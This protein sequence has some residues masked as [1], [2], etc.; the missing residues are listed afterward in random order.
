MLAQEHPSA[1][2]SDYVL[3]LLPAPKLKQIERHLAEC[4]ACLQQV[5]RERAMARAL[6]N[7][8]RDTPLPA[9]GR[10]AE[11]MPAPPESRGPLA[12]TV[13]WRPAL[14]LSLFL[15]IFLGGMHMQQSPGGALAYPSATALSVTATRTPTATTAT[16]SA[17]EPEAEFQAVPDATPAARPEGTPLA[18]LEVAAE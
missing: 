17:A 14:A 13:L 3:G 9:Q 10:L 11:L 15:V 4:D 1:L 7:T 2:L 12:W 8:L 16:E 5:R 18:S 6:R